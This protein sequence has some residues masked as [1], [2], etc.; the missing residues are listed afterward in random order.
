MKIKKIFI[1]VDNPNSWFTKHAKTLKKKIERLKINCQFVTNE[2]KLTTSADI[3]FYL[4]CT[5]MTKIK[6]LAKFKKNIVVHGSNL[7]KGRGHAPWAW[8]ILAGKNSIDLSLFEI[9]LKNNQPDSGS[10]YLRDNFTLKGTELLNEIRNII[11]NRIIYLCV[12]F[13]KNYNK[14]KPEK[15]KGKATYFRMRKPKDQ[16]LDVNKSILSQF[17]ILRT[18]DN[19]RWPAFFI[20]KKNKYLLK[21]KKQLVIK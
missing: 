10:V 19:K 16:K 2:K 13:L 18:A 14:I 15:Q 5:K 20:Y 6:T 7:P 17:N 11:A 1:L 21:I 4:S 9:D 12:K 8:S 3:C